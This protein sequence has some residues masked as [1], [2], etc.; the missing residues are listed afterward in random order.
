MHL[1]KAKLSR[2]IGL[3]TIATT[4]CQSDAQARL[5]PA[6]MAEVSASATACHKADAMWN[7]KIL[8][9][10]YAQLPPLTRPGMIDLFT[11]MQ[12]SYSEQALTSHGDELAPG[13]QKLVHAFGAEGRM[14]LVVNP[15]A[16]PVNP[17]PTHRSPDWR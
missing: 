9:S 15:A 13:R 6:A 17:T 7:E 10:R 5:A 14:Q 4:A 3:I 11:L 12:S 1:F 8:P 2:L 16:M